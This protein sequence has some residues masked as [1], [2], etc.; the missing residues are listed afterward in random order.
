MRL[1]NRFRPQHVV[2]KTTKVNSK[3]N[4]KRLAANYAVLASL[5]ATSSKSKK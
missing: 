1:A 2:N 4:A 5:A 3:K